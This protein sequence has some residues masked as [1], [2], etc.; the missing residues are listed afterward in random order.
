M[1]ILNELFGIREVANQFD[2]LCDRING[3]PDVFDL[4]TENSRDSHDALWD[5]LV[6]QFCWWALATDRFDR[7]L[8]LWQCELLMDAMWRQIEP[9]ISHLD[10]NRSDGQGKPE[11]ILNIE[12]EAECNS[13]I[14]GILKWLD[15]DDEDADADA[16]LTG[17]WKGPLDKGVLQYVKHGAFDGSDCGCPA[18]GARVSKSVYRKEGKI[19]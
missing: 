16:E 8:P 11:Q 9:V 6:S 3:L 19:L 5:Q 15:R 10:Q 14:Q 4:I 13:A 17:V 18:D 7:P 12:S 1:T 2:I